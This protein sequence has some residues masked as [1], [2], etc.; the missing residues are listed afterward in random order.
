M[1]P[2]EKD[3]RRKEDTAFAASWG[4]ISPQCGLSVVPE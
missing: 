1:G 3:S 4:Y 2:I